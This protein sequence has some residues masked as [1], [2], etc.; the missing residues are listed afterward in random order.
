MIRVIVERRVKRGEDI[1]PLLRELRANAIQ[2]PGY[3]TGES[4]AST[5][6]GSNIV[7]LSTWQTL[8]AWKSWEK[9]RIRVG[10]NNQ[11]EALLVEKSKV[12]TYRVIST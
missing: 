6:D 11:V 8:E 7:V 4:L 3:V 1:L 12:N 9:S 5:E 10:I 2:Y